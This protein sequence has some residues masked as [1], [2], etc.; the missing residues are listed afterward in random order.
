[1]FLEFIPDGDDIS[2]W[3]FYSHMSNEERELIWT[4]VFVFP[5]ERPESI[6]WRKY[7]KTME[8][9]HEKGCECEIKKNEERKKSGKK[10]QRYDGAI[11][12]RVVDIRKIRNS[13]KHGFLV[14]HDP[15]NEQGIH[16]AQIRYDVSHD[17][18]FTKQD[19]IELKS[20]LKAVFSDLFPHACRS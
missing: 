2:R 9:V 5:N 3:I 7:L 15:S 20:Q 8:E 6:V 13:K 10:L 11:N 14:E 16:H 4:G 19:K 1:M 18:D 12:A 17:Y